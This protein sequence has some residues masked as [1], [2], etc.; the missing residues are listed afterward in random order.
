MR[1]DAEYPVG[2]EISG[3]QNKDTEDRF[4]DRDP[5]HG[6]LCYLVLPQPRAVPEPEPGPAGPDPALT[7]ALAALAGIPGLQELHAVTARQPG[8]P[9]INTPGKLL[10]HAA[11][12]G[13]VITVPDPPQKPESQPHNRQRPDRGSLPSK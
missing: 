12:A 8:D 1:D 2:I 7:A 9:R 13:I 5:G 3:R 10:E 4:I 11:A 6:G